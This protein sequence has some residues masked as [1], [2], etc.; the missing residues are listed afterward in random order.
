MDGKVGDYNPWAP[1]K[2]YHTHIN[3]LAI[4]K[5][6]PYDPPTIFF[7]ECGKDGA[8]TS[9][10]VPVIPQKPKAGTL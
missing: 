6:S 3:F 7:A 5:G 1:D 10:C 2:Y 4:C 9:W 8:A